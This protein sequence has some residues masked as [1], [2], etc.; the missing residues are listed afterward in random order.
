MAQL[1]LKQGQLTQALEFTERIAAAAADGVSMPAIEDRM[2]PRLL[3]YRVWTVA[4]DARAPAVSQPCTPNSW[5]LPRPRV[6][7]KRVRAFSSRSL[8]TAR[9]WPPGP[10]VRR[11][12]AATER[13]DAAFEG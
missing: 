12:Y 1:H 11:R 4:G 10:I 2:F 7:M 6:T 9:S 3:C 8:S 5:R 13:I